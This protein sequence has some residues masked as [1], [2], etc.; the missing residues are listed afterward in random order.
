MGNC[1]PIC[2]PEKNEIIYGMFC[3]QQF[4]FDILGYVGRPPFCRK[5]NLAIRAVDGFLL[6]KFLVQAGHFSVSPP[7]MKL[8]TSLN[9]PTPG[10]CR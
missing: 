3:Q 4:L 1:Q 8:L 7:Q 10:V 6:F 2:Q 9:N 5:P